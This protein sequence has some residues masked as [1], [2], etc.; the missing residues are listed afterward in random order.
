MYVT[1]CELKPHLERAGYYAQYIALAKLIG[2]QQKAQHYLAAGYGTFGYEPNVDYFFGIPRAITTGGAVMNI[3]IL[4]IT[5]TDSAPD[6]A[7]EDKKNYTLQI[8]ILSSALE[9]AVPEQLFTTDPANPADAI[10]AVKALS[11][12]SAQGQRIYHITQANQNIALANINHD[13]YTMAEIRNA[14]A[15]GKEV[16]THTDVVSVPGWSGAGYIII[17]PVTG[18]GA[19]KIGGGLNGSLLGF[20]ISFSQSEAVG[21]GLFIISILAVLASAPLSAVLVIAIFAIAIFH[22]VMTTMAVVSE[23]NT[24][25]CPG[26]TEMLWG[27]SALTTLLPKFFN[28]S[29]GA[30]VMSFYN[31]IARN[32]ADSVVPACDVLR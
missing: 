13:P 1:F 4:N 24:S 30:L 12:A 16:M 17:D 19:Y 7:A 5:A 28:V 31:F 10:S 14:L 25:S 6:T 29:G 32:T 18:S 23:S 3:P 27:F 26:L 20:D 15:V 8:G 9:H 22:A 11:K 21:V 2:Q